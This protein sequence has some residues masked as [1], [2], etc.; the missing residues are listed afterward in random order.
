MK[1]LDRKLLADLRRMWGQALAISLVMACGVATFVM[2]TSMLRSLEATRERYYRDYRFADVF[3]HLK[4]A[5]NQLAARVA[6]IPGV[7][8]VQ[9]RVTQS[10]IL[11]IPGMVEPATARLLS[12]PDDPTGDLNALH[13]RRGRLPDATRRGEVVLSE[14][15]AEAHGLQPGDSVQAILNGTKERLLVVGIGLSPEYVYAVQPGGFLPDNR[16]FGVF[17]MSYRQI[18]AA[19]DMDGAF[20]DLSATLLPRAILADVVFQIDQL[21]GPYGGQGAYGREDQASHRRVADEM[22]QLRSMALVAPLIFLSV[23]AFL[24]NVVLSRMIQGQREEIATLRAFGYTSWEIGRHYLKFIS[25]LVAG[26]VILGIAVGGWLARDLSETYGRFFRFPVLEIAPAADGI[27][28]AVLMSLAAGILGG[29]SAVRRAMRQPPA[30]AMRP[31]PPPTYRATFLDKLRV[32]PK[33]SPV[34][35][36]ILRRFQRH[37]RPTVLSILG[38]ALGEAVVVLGTFVEDTVDYVIAVQ[39][40]QAQRQDATVSFQETLSWRARHDVAHLPGVRTAEPFRAVPVRLRHGWRTRRLSVLGLEEEQRLFRVLDQNE[41][42]V[43]LQGDGLFV[44]NKLAELLGAQ[45]GDEVTLEV[46]EGE[47]VTRQVTIMSVF[48]DYTEPGAYMNRPALHRLLR[49]GECLSGAFV[50]LD[51]AE[52]E[53]FYQAAKATPALAGLSNKQAVIDSFRSTIRENLMRMRAV[54]II[55]ASIIAFGVIYNCARITLAERSRELAT[56]RVLG[57]SRWEISAV[58]LGE[59]AIIALAALP[60]GLV[61]G[62]GLSYFATLALDTET[63]RFPL[64]INRSTYAYAASVVILAV[65]VSSLIVRRMLDKLDVVA[66]LKAKE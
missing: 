7:A 63:H 12:L 6:E 38:I 43:S 3:L 29:L 30:E 5:P 18:A 13:L 62:Y 16:R 26:G 27:A 54:N 58:L 37:W 61:F 8:R 60:L 2:S 14:A 52:R 64:V 25:I 17:W 28:L 34:T 10:A 9:T 31:E 56:M 49:E 22:L 33:L 53:A 41:Q 21:T 66:V 40:R 1:A 19:F 20:N 23:A 47:R 51:E 48:P 39:F 59:L 36:M 42:R 44:S 65:T 45:V 4:R 24:F 57:F 46:L 32:L 11:D 55:F 50:T 15:F 35:L